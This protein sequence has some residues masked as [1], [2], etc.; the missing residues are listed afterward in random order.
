VG[1]SKIWLA[2]QVIL[3][4]KQGLAEKFRSKILG[5][6]KFWAAEWEA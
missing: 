6:L 4:E 5:V 2:A 1:I 3:D